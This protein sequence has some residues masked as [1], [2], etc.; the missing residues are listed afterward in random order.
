MARQGIESRP[1]VILFEEYLLSI[2]TSKLEIV[3][4]PFSAKRRV[5]DNVFKFMQVLVDD[6]QILVDLPN[7]VLAPSD[8][9]FLCLRGF[10]EDFESSFQPLQ[11]FYSLAHT[12]GV[13]ADLE[14]VWRELWL[15]RSLPKVEIYAC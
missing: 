10:A 1:Q 3:A 6:K 11:K 15:L 2:D 13:T 12:D 4:E 7:T 8:A 9:M 14:F 5:T